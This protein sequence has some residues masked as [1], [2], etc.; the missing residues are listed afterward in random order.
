MSEPE[1][2][3]RNPLRGIP[4]LLQPVAHGLTAMALVLTLAAGACSDR[5]SAIAVV[6]R[7]DV[8]VYRPLIHVRLGSGAGTREMAAAFPSAARFTAVPTDGDLPLVVVL[9][10]SAGDTIARYTGAPIRLRK[11]T[12]YQVNVSVGSQ[13]PR[14]D[15]CTGS[16]V[17]S[18]IAA[19]PSL[20]PGGA[21]GAE[22]LFVSVSAFD[23]QAEPPRCDD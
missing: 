20:T 3:L 14:S 1:V 23:R 8:S 6:Y 2:W 18:A 9:V 7:G 4:P 15:R 12:S 13:R 11:Q 5:G 22:S 17:G 16:W 21:P 19:P 10:A